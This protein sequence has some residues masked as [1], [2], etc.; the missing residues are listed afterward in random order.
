MNRVRQLFIPFFLYSYIISNP[1]QQE[2]KIQHIITAGLACLLLS[3]NH[4]AAQPAKPV[5]LPAGKAIFIPKD[6]QSMDLQDPESKWSYHRMA[7]TDNFV[8]FWEKGFGSDL[9]N[10]PALEG[11]PMKVDLPN[12][13][14]KLERFY[15][16][17]R[18]TLQF[19]K[20]GSKSEQYRMMVMINYSLEGTAY[21]GDYDQTIGALWVA[22]NRIQDYKLNCIAHELGHS[23]QAQIMCDGEGEA[24]GGTGF[25]EMASQW[26]LWQVNP[27]WMTDE[28][29]HWVDYMKQTH[30]AYLHFANIYHSPYVLEYWCEK[31]GLP[32]IAELFRQGKR[33]EDPVIT[34]KRLGGLSQAAFCDEMFDACRHFINWDLTH[35]HRE[36]RSYA[37]RYFTELDTLKGGWFRIAQ[38]KCPENYGFNAIR[39]EVPAPG[40]TASVDFQGEAGLEGY[41]SVQPDKAGWRY[42]FVAVTRSGQ[43]IYGETAGSKQ[44]K[45]RF[46]T[47][48]GELI[49]HLWFV[50]MGAPEAH[51]MNPGGWGKEPEPDAQWP[52][53]F[54]VSGSQVIQ[55]VASRPTAWNTPGAGNPLLPGY[56]ADPTVKKFGDTY[57]LYAT[58]DGIK[59]ASGEPQVWVSKDFVN[60]YNY[61]MDLDLPEGLTNCWAPDVHQGDDEK[62]YFF[63]GNCQFGCNIYGYVSDTPVGPWKPVN[64]G[65]PVIPVGSGKERLPALDAQFISIGKD[66]YLAWFGTWCTSFGGLGWADIDARTMTI[67]REGYLP[68]EQL[69]HVFEA[70]YPLRKGDKWLM[71]YSSGDCRLSTYAVHYAVAD[72]AHGPYQYGKN[73][74]I[75]STSADGT[76]DSPGHNSVVEKDGNYY[77]LYHRHDNPHSSGGEFRQVA[78]DRLIFSDNQTLEVVKA[79]HDGIGYLGANT[80]PCPNLAYQAK[81]TATSHYHLVAPPNRYNTTGINQTYFPRYAVD[82]N[83]GTMWKAADATFPQ[84]LVVDLGKATDIRRVMTQFEYPT[85]YYQYRIDTSTDSLN[86]MP[87]ADRTANR[88]SGSP[89][90]DD[91]QAVARYLRLTVTGAEKTGMF[92]AIWNLKVYDQLFETPAYR[93][94]EVP[95]G[96]GV[97]STG[98]LLVDWK[99]AGQPDGLLAATVKNE[100]S[101]GGEF[102]RVGKAEITET[103][104]VRSLLLDGKGYLK[105]SVPAP[106]SLGWNAPYTA[107]AWVY[108]PEV[109]VGECILSWTSREDMLQA[110]YTAMMYGKSNYG[111]VAHGDGAVDVGFREVPEAGQWHHLTV[112]FDGMCEYVYVDGRLDRCFP[113]T[114]FVQNSEV[115]IG[116]SGER[117]E[118]YSG[119]IANVQLYDRFMAADEIAHLMHATCPRACAHK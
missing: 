114:L 84:S 45:I 66:K 119:S 1:L 98:S 70:A 118:N 48:K 108:N 117:S 107:S 17:F 89:M 22:P 77:I 4:L 116:S 115:R 34:Y 9:A 79:G 21:G 74:P 50:V 68:L 93:N 55:T 5:E 59:L 94:K 41:A 88:A 23:F 87:F 32:V 40:K 33:G 27:L 6:L 110:S 106:A 11:K 51:W 8:V 26:M 19:V 18:D 25:F 7:C 85:F 31:R 13:L 91:G 28:E 81:A 102:I 39:I 75:L 44:G 38:T 36:A 105:L 52:Y 58:T 61:E 46:T 42:G 3:A 109:G 15:Q 49:E 14:D 57:Y 76:I 24:W 64:N 99:A 63:M 95:E 73:N 83:N 65:E 54:K 2:M 69:P 12:L 92:A 80:I 97:P 60:W 104:G 37:N 35:A 112:T 72:E 10:P 113:L 47:P 56:F 82:D 78:A 67:E 16:Y 111:A 101:L 71:M 30:K 103:D 20:P 100:G 29:Y 86:W 90:I 96:P 43:T 62:Y 53:R